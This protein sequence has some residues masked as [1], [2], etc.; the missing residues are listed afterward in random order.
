MLEQPI[1]PDHARQPGEV[2]EQVGQ[3][4]PAAG[5]EA[6]AVARS[7]L[8]EGLGQRIGDRP[9]GLA[10]DPGRLP[11][12]SRVA[13]IHLRS[14]RRGW[15]LFGRIAP[16]EDPINGARP[17]IPMQVDSGKHC[18]GRFGRPRLRRPSVVGGWR[19]MIPVEPPIRFGLRGCSRLGTLGPFWRHGHANRGETGVGS[20]GARWLSLRISRHERGPII[21]STE[22]DRAATASASTHGRGV[23]KTQRATATTL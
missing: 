8:P 19:G 6:V 15:S 17:S 10:A 12:S 11:G 5:P 16:G 4:R 13:S 14:S 18:P 1:E 3:G 21:P 22:R 20:P 9:D 7:G 2:P 23:R